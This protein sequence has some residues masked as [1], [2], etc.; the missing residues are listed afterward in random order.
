VASGRMRTTVKLP[1]P[2]T[3]W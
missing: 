1:M 2:T 3:C